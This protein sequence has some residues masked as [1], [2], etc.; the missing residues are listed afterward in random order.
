MLILLNTFF[1]LFIAALIL[2]FVSYDLRT[3]F[4]DLFKPLNPSKEPEQTP[5]APK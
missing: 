1:L 5:P 2:G 4:G 3:M